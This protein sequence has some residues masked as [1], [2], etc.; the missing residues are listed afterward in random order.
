MT[1]LAA[2]HKAADH[3]RWSGARRDFKRDW[4]P[5]RLQLFPCSPLHWRGTMDQTF[6]PGFEQGSAATDPD[7]RIAYVRGGS[8]PLLLLLHCYPQT[9]AI[10][11]RA[12][13]A[14]ARRF[15]LVARRCPYLSWA[16]SRLGYRKLRSRARNSR[17]P[18]E[19]ALAEFWPTG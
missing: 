19:T 10:W 4:P 8:G 11:H 17:R 13:P 5:L 15:T 2:S 1:E 7:V 14:L 16:C 3:R 6:F 9:S 18:E 12:A